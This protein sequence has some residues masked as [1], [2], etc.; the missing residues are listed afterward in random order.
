MLRYLQKF[1]IYMKSIGYKFSKNTPK[2]IRR[3]QPKIIERINLTNKT[4]EE[5]LK[6]FQE[7]H[8]YNIRLANK[9]GVT[10]REGTRED[11]PIFYDIMKRQ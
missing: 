5:L 6:S 4:E 1:K 8:R 3:M 9:K 7:K 10:L 2:T 11:L